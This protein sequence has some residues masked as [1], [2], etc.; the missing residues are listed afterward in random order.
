MH[1]P[2][3]VLGHALPMC[4]STT[5]GMMGSLSSA[6][7][8]SQKSE[9]KDSNRATTCIHKIRR[10][11]VHLLK[12]YTQKHSSVLQLTLGW[13]FVSLI[14]VMGEGSSIPCP[15]MVGPNTLAKLFW[16]IWHSGLSITLK[17]ANIVAPNC[18]N[19]WKLQFYLCRCST[20]KASVSL[21]GCGSSLMVCN[22]ISVLLSSSA[23]SV[24]EKENSGVRVCISVSI[25]L[26]M[27]VEYN[28]YYR[29]IKTLYQLHRYWGTE[30]VHNHL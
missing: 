23:I 4:E 8:P 20:R 19:P 30:Q 9:G 5:G 18:T 10:Q 26:F 1:I 24:R 15:M 2:L 14:M 27:E 28:R 7:R 22:N 16:S 25:T 3:L 11:S 17:Q 29:W 21:L 6:I 12:I 13:V